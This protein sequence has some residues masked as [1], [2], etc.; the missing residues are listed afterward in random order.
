MPRDDSR[1]DALIEDIYAAALGDTGWED[2]LHGL[3]RL[4]GARMATLLSYDDTSQLASIDRAVGDDDAWMASCHHDYSAEFYLYDPG[5]PVIGSWAPGRWFEDHAFVTRQQRARSVFYQEFMRPNQLGS[6]SGIFVHRHQGD[7]AF[8]S[9]LGGPGSQGL[10]PAQQR[11]CTALG[12]HFS[13][14]LRI[15]ARLGQ[16]EARAAL[17]ESTLEGLP[18]PVFL[19]DERR[20]LI[21]ANLAAAKLMASEAVL[22]FVRGRFVPEVCS[23]DAQW[24]EALNRGGI[25]LRRV[26]GT[27]LILALMPVPAHAT[28]ALQQNR[29]VT[30]MTSIHL[31]TSG[32][33]Q[34]RLQLFYGLTASEAQVAI[35]VSCDG[36]SP[37][38]CA[39]ARCVSAGTV[40]SQLKSIHSK[41]GVSRVADLVRLVLAT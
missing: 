12:A 15:Q 37:T 36:L 18:T 26:D 24:R 3:R 22:R 13:H 30:L 8:L 27:K 39:E 4:T 20:T 1:L 25:Q 35:A 29:N 23:D 21:F 33:R 19:L 38:E 40:R 17:A 14:A 5:A 32:A 2:A 7:S 6:I 41:M 31:S 10:A 34:T 28:L 16:G 9:L 11:T